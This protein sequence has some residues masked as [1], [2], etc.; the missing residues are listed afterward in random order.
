M[1]EKIRKRIGFDPNKEVVLYKRVPFKGKKKR[2]LKNSKRKQDR[3]LLKSGTIQRYDNVDPDNRYVSFIFPMEEFSS[4]KQFKNWW[5]NKFSGL[6]DG[7][8]YLR[9]Y[10][11]EYYQ[12]FRH[13]VK[14]E[15]EGGEI[16]NMWKKSKRKKYGKNSRSGRYFA[17]NHYLRLKKKGEI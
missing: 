16:K 15:M 9:Q 17:L 7:I 11:T 10:Q 6:D 13:I 2:R 3:N 8:Y 12:G 1:R 5:E 4:E 14:L